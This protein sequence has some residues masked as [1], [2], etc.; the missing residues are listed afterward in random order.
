MV[1]AKTEFQSLSAPARSRFFLRLSHEL[2]VRARGA[3]EPSSSGATNPAALRAFNE[4]QHEIVG[5]LLHMTERGRHAYPD[6]VL[7]AILG[8]IAGEA[9]ISHHYCI[10]TERAMA[11]L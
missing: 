2:T 3:Y 4:L 11:E 7:V 10:A 1:E 6:D 8:D 9:A 5:H